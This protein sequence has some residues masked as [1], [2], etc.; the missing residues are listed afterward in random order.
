LFKIRNK[1]RKFERF[2]V[3]AAVLLK[4][5]VF[6]GSDVVVVGRIASDISEAG[7]ASIFRVKESYFKL[8]IY[9]LPSFKQSGT[10]Y[11]KT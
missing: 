6:F 5:K 10:I 4:T 1:I 3:L 9:A 2:E 8:N 11:P 7:T